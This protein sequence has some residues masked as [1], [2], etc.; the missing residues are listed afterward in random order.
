ML[1]FSVCYFES[2]R[3]E[4]GRWFGCCGWF[5]CCHRVTATNSAP[6]LLAALFFF[7]YFLYTTDIAFILQSISLTGL[8][9]SSAKILIK[10]ILKLLEMKLNR[11]ENSINQIL[12]CAFLILSTDVTSDLITLNS[13]TYFHLLP[14]YFFVVVM[15]LLYPKRL[16]WIFSLAHLSFE[17]QF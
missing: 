8:C 13:N 5:W 6:L 14:S 1:S 11:H 16:I 7:S 17:Y 4:S 9:E 10:N 12:C 2:S 15:I 3:V